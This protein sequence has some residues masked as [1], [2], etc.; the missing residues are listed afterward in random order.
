MGSEQIVKDRPVR[1]MKGES[2]TCE[3]LGQMS[4]AMGVGERQVRGQ[5]HTG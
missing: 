3:E 2:E 4:Q 5:T 1:A